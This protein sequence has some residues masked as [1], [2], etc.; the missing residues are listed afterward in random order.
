M[1]KRPRVRRRFRKYR[2]FAK[3][4][5]AF[6]DSLGYVTLDQFRPRDIDAF[7]IGLTRVE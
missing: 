1:G 2:T 4:L 5:R 6:S 7:Y 3:Q